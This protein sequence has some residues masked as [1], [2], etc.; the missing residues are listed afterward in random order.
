MK[1]PLPILVLATA[2]VSG[3]ACRSAQFDPASKVESVRILA[4]RSDKPYAKPGD[5]VN[6]EV[7][8]ADDRLDKT[9]P[10]TVQWVPVPCID[11]PNDSYFGCYP[12][13]AQL[14]AG[15]DLTP[16]LHTGT[17]Y[18]FTM[19][20]DVITSHVKRTGSVDADPNGLAVIF[21]IACA[22]HVEYVPPK[23]NGSPN[24]MP[25]GCF[26]ADHNALGP[27]QY[28]F[29]FS[30]VYAFNDRTNANP[31]IDQLTFG[32][33]PVDPNVG[34][35]VDHCGSAAADVNGTVN[36]SNCPKTGMDIVV[37]DSSWELNP[38]DLDA[39]GNP[40]KEE[41]RVQY[42]STDG[43]FANDTINLFDATAGRITGTSDDFTAPALAGEN[44]IWAV[45]RDDRGG[46]TWL[47]I[48]LHVR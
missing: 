36:R 13:F 1:G 40:K 14:P 3:E 39:N 35:T 7:L 9:V 15:V 37:P 4:T 41:I 45:V 44:M 43:K 48:P 28:V 32:G 26:D 10:M 42:F 24:A 46:A 20:T 2:L 22:G 30:L 6:M 5:T 27:D 31:V 34:I 18:S 33:T 11:P 25:L 21:T 47:S 16:V 12:G 38:S 8:A 29:A 23:V 19:P 17:T